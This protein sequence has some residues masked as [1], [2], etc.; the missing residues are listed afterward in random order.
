MMKIIISIKIAPEVGYG[1]FPAGT[2]QK[3]EKN[4]STVLD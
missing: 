2:T 3:H 4:V 1:C